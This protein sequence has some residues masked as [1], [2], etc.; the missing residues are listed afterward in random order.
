MGDPNEILARANEV[1]LQ[2]SLQQQ[3]QASAL[4][5]QNRHLAEQS[6]TDGLAGVANLRHF[7]G[8]VTSQFG[9][10]QFKKSIDMSVLFVDASNF[11]N[12]NDTYGH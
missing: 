11:K 4:E 9:T 1:L 5:T 3:Q 12:V 10:T 7:H 6:F 2:I 8:F